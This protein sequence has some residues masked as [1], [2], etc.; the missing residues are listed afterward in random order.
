MEQLIYVVVKL[1]AYVLWCGVGVTLFRPQASS[2]FASALKFG[3]VRLLL[4]VFLGVTVF[5]GAWMLKIGDT[6]LS[7][8]A[9]YLLMYIPLRWVEWSI[10][11]YLLQ[12]GP[13]SLLLAPARAYAP[14][15]MATS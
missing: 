9:M 5:L 4:G 6:G 7:H 12:P 8:L 2:K 15:P 3:F 11:G 14:A 13:R 10:M 1:A